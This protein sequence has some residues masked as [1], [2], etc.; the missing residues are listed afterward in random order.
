MNEAECMWELGEKI[1]GS[2]NEVDGNWREGNG[3]FGEERVGS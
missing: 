1:L 2:G 3:N